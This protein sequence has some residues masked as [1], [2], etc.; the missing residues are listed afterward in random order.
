M[1][2]LDVAAALAPVDGADPAGPD[3]GYDPAFAALERAARGKPEQQIGATVVPAEEPDWKLVQRQ[4]LELAAKTRDVRVAVYLTKALARTSGWSGL[5]D[6]L[7]LVRG[8]VERYWDGGLHPRLDPD[9]DN[10]PTMRINALREL[11][12]PELLS[13]LKT[14][15]L[16]VSKVLGPI[17]LRHVEVA[18]GEVPASAESGD[19]T[20]AAIEGSL[21]ELGPDALKALESTLAACRD[22]LTGIEAVAEGKVPSDMALGLDKAVALMSKAVVVVKAAIGEPASAEGA[23][24]GTDGGTARRGKFSGEISSRE[25]VVR[26]LDK[27]CA[28]YQKYEPSSPIPMFMERSKRLVMMSFVDIVKELVPEAVAQVA[29]LQGPRE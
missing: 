7:A 18:N 26:A 13:A 20:P 25:D 23:T 27:I 3:L 14:I 28:Y 8:L 21:S 6:G 2:P 11:A 15:P 9:D 29:I 12:A 17:T 1:P 19:M 4:A 22:G 24:V 16:A 10:D 5:A